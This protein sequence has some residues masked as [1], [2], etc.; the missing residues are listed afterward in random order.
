LLGTWQGKG[1]EVWNPHKSNILQL[2]VSL[3][4]LVLTKDPYYNEAGYDK[5]IG[6]KEGAHNSMLYNESAYLLTLKSIMAMIRK[7]PRQFEGL[8]QLHYAQNCYQIIQRSERLLQKQVVVED[9]NSSYSG[10]DILIY[11]QQSFTSLG[12]KKALEAI[13]PKLKQTLLSIAPNSIFVE[14]AQ[15]ATTTTTTNV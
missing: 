9:N 14:M 4:G 11:E 6:S 5:Q 7:P 1:S 10:N 8:V 2:L 15:N 13:L 3:Q 12:F